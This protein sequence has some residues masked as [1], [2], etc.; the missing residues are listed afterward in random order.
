[1]S[2]GPRGRR[3]LDPAQDNVVVDAEVDDQVEAAALPDERSVEH[4]RLRDRPREA[5]EDPVLGRERRER[6][7]GERQHHVVRDKVWQKGRSL[8]SAAREKDE[9]ERAVRT[10]TGDQLLGLLPQLGALCDLLAQDVADAHLRAESKS[11]TVPR[12]PEIGA[13]DAPG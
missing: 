10:S 11:A 5:V 4:G 9:W 8:S 1:M 7:Q 6:A 12:T 3:T 2:A 13:V